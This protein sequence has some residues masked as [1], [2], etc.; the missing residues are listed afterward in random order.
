[1]ELAGLNI[2][3][4]LLAQLDVVFRLAL[5]TGGQAWR[6]A[7]TSGLDRSRVGVILGSIALPTEGISAI[8]RYY[9]GRTLYERLG[10]ECPFAPAER[11]HG[12]L[13]STV[14]S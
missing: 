4:D 8:T 7:V 3:P 6:S 9:L 2:D 11:P 13:T 14:T 12:Q 1:M 5:E 10:R